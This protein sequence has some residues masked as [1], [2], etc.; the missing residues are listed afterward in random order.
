MPVILR[1]ISCNFAVL[2]F[3][4]ISDQNLILGFL[5][6][7]KPDSQR[8]TTPE[9]FIFHKPKNEVQFSMSAVLDL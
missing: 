1:Q 4:V 9:T 6:L 3:F 2:D 8:I 5:Y 7:F